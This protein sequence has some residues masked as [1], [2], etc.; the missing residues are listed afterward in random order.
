MIGPASRESCHP[1]DRMHAVLVVPTAVQSKAIGFIPSRFREGV[2]MSKVSSRGAVVLKGKRR[3]LPLSRPSPDAPDGNRLKKAPTGIDGFDEITRGG[4]PAGRPTLVCGGAG[5]GKT[6]FALEFLVQGATR[7]D[8]PGVFIAFEETAEELSAN[9]ASLGFDLDRLVDEGK[10]LIDYIHLERSEIEHAGEFD[11]EGL[12]IRLGHAI[13]TI[14]AKRVVLDTLEV[15]FA[16]LP[17]EA[18]LRAELRRLFRWLKDK[19]VSAIVTAEKGLGA[20]TRHGLEEYVSDCVVLL[21]HRVA[22]QVSTRRLRVVKYRGTTHETNE[23]PFLIDEGGISVLPLSSLALDHESPT[24]RVATGIPDLDE[25]LG[26]AGFYRGST[27]LATGMAGAGKTS[28]AAHFTRSVCESGGRC[29]YF[30]FEESRAQIVRNMRSIGI[31]LD[32]WV[33]RGLLRIEAARPTLYGLERHLVK[34]HKLVTEFRPDAVVIDPISNLS[35]AGSTGETRS[36]HMRLI[37]FLKGEGVTV[38]M[39]SLTHGAD[40]NPETTDLCVSSLVDTWLLLRSFEADGERNRGL[41]IL[42]SRG[43][44]HSNQVREFLLTDRGIQLAAVT[45]GPHGVLTGAARLAH[46]AQDLS[47]S[48][49][50]L[51]EEE[52]RRLATILRRTALETQITALRAVFGEEEGEQERLTRQERSRE[53]ALAR[54]RI[55]K[56]R[57]RMIPSP[58]EVPPRPNGKR[59]EGK[60]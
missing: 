37:D 40:V 29:L 6:L 41:F 22:D 25:M 46:R 26:G 32:P 50:H 4:L 35:T 34:M 9:V 44:A 45:L 59:R 57:A 31:D 36:M 49:A 11:L 2:S 14:G 3:Q 18:T 52:R 20:M 47:D 21:D 38:F 10:L 33:E 8:E 15:L 16:V 39:T 5:C 30:A 28:M 43:M 1:S 55:G 56:E 13:D 19:G 42:K 53:D 60:K 54:D 7:F 24:E 48:R 58:S 12:F 23:F 51:E 17:D 27:V